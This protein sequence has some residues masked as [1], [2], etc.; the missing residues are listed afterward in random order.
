MASISIPRAELL[1]AL[2]SERLVRLLEQIFGLPSEIEVIRDDLAAHVADTTDA[3]PASSI[4]F[5]PAGGMVATQVQ[6][7]LLELNAGKQPLDADLTSWAGVARAAG[8]D[9][10]AATPDSANLRALLTDETGT[11]A[12]V[13]ADSPSLTTPDIGA[14]TGASLAATGAITSSGGGIGYATGA[15]GTVAQITSKATGV[16]LNKLTGEITMHN[17][18]LAANTAVTFTL[19]NSTIAATDVMTVNVVSGAT[20]GA[21]FV[22]PV[23]QAGAAQITVRNLTAGPLSEAIVLRFVI[24]RGATA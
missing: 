16:T 7:A 19:T 18:A 8:F 11:G 12:A 21:Y 14:A 20:A 4:G 9:A 17:A 3:H 13:F 23:C 15:G 10:F 24:H 6:A 22:N 5:A 1:Q 2:K